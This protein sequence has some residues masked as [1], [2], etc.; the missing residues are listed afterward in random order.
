[1]RGGSNACGMIHCRI[2]NEGGI[3]AGLH[4][5]V[6]E[7]GEGRGILNTDAAVDPPV[8]RA[9][10]AISDQH[11]AIRSDRGAGGCDACNTSS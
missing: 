1:M 9:F 11:S 5:N 4:T 10:A 6:A 3:T 8:W 2:S 7:R